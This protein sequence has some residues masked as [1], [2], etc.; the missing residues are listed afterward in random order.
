MAIDKIFKSSN[1]DDLADNILS[2]VDDFMVSVKQMQQRKAT[3]N[4]QT[5][6]HALK[7]IETNIQDKF[8]NVTDVI[9]K[10][11]LTIKDGRDGSSGSDGRNGRDGKPGRDGVNG[12]QGTPGT[13]GKDGVDGEDGVSVTNANIDFD[14][15]LVISLSSG[16]QIN[17][18]EVVAPDLAEKI[19]IVSTMSTNGAVGIKDEGTSITTGVK[20]INF[21]GASVTATASGDDVTVNVSS[22]TGTVTSVAISGGTTGLTTSGGPIITSGT[23]TLAGTL[24]NTSGGTGQSSAFTQYGVTYAS[25]TSVLAVTAAGTTGQVLTATTSGAPTWV[26][27]A[28]GGTVTSA[29]VVS[30]NGF[31]GT[32]AT[33]TTTP[34][35][36]LTTSITG[37]LKGNGT[38]IS[39]ATA[40]TDYV[41]P[42]GTETL[43]N[44]TINGASNTVTNIS[45]ATGVT[46]NLPVTNLNSGTSASASTFWRGDATWGAIS[47]GFTLGTPVVTTSGT[48]ID[49]TSIPAGTKQIIISFIDVSSNGSA[50]FLI[51]I[52]DSG[53]IET[54]SY[55]SLVMKSIDGSVPEASQATS[56][57]ILTRGVSSGQALRGMVILQL[58]NSSS[59]TWACS[60]TL[61]P[62]GN[63]LYSLAGWKSLSGELDRVRLTTDGSDTFDAGEIN[64]AYI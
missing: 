6:I 34:A 33:A 20:N 53:G 46:G 43:T 64:I 1:V 62:A 63:I 22:G 27:P 5:V 48:S 31:A 41:T 36:T 50:N 58:E 30:A 2:E 37:V 4:V 26:S 13:P 32:V 51:R 57:F 24:A 14:G 47:A 49:F 45:L 54:S 60:G 7:K 21:V 16:Q 40:G 8:D 3:E 56:G 19:K 9:E 18:G 28:S 55:T 59:Y 52:G 44:K 15:S 12:K 42:T 61:V 38:A 23:V 25:T 10:R 17:V 11:V 29:S 39:A 35:I